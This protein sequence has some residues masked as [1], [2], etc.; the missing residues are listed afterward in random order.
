[1]P[2]LWL[3]I[4]YLNG[5]FVRGVFPTTNLLA[6]FTQWK[7]GVIT[8]YTTL[9]V[10]RTER[11]RFEVVVAEVESI[12]VIGCVGTLAENQ[13]NRRLNETIELNHPATRRHR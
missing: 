6:Y 4:R 10:D 2:G 9:G 1:M 7:E 8:I 3:Q 11:V 5:N 13:R 12:T